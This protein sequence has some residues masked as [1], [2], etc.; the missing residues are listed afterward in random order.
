MREYWVAP[1]LDLC[2]RHHAPC[3]I[4]AHGWFVGCDPASPGWPNGS[5]RMPP[6]Q[7]LPHLIGMSSP[8]D[9]QPIAGVFESQLAHRS[10]GLITRHGG[11]NARRVQTCF[12]ALAQLTERGVSG[13]ISLYGPNGPRGIRDE[14]PSFKA[15][16]SVV[17]G[18]AGI[19]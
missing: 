19:C 14:K 7:S 3:L 2:I 1:F 8:G 18:S 4:R 10:R 11:V 13:I 9:W 12:L 16:D 5:L 6:D 15:A 17:G